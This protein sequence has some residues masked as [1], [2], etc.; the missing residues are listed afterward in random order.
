MRARVLTLCCL[1]ALTAGCSRSASPP[2]TPATPATPSEQ[3]VSY[4]KARQGATT[5]PHGK[6]RIDTVMEEG[7]KIRYTTANGAAWRVPYTK[8]ADGTYQ[9]GTP[10]EVKD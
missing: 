5:T 7:G 6:I 9:Y 1:L 4:F 8:Q 2:A 10:E 3:A